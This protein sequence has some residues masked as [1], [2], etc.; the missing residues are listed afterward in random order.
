MKIMPFALAATLLAVSCV[1]PSAAAPRAEAEGGTPKAESAPAADPAPAVAS[2]V[3]PAAAAD[4]GIAA[5]QGIGLAVFPEPQAL[6]PLEVPTP[7]GK[8][9]RLVDY[10]GKYVFLNFWATWCPP[11]KAEMPSME[12]LFAALDGN[13]FGIMAI[14]V[15][16]KTET[17][18]KFMSENKYTFPIGMDSDGSLGA[19]FAGRGI[20]TTYILDRKGRAIAG[21]IGGREW[22]DPETVAAFKL[23]LSGKE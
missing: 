7:D 5:L 20:P 6:P 12:R 18:R 4:P 11:C 16:E 3:A 15:G 23:L 22:D 13:D 8:T 14:S 19:M 1:P 10:A 21:V 2:P 17:V 9:L